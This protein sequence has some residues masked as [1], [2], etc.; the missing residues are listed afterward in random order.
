MTL[1]LFSA[2]IVKDLSGCF[3]AVCNPLEAVC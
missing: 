2:A 3:A 1:L